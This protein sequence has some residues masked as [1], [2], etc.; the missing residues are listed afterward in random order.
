MSNRTGAHRGTEVRSKGGKWKINTTRPLLTKLVLTKERETRGWQQY[1][2]GTTE[3]RSEQRCSIES[4][5]TATR[6]PKHNIR[7]QWTGPTGIFGLEPSNKGTDT[8]GK[9]Q[10][11]A[12]KGRVKRVREEKL[13]AAGEAE[14]TAGGGEN[15]LH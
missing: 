13:A 6:A 5:L 12:H 3:G 4:W 7:Q 1:P 8:R 14:G 9:M 10:S 11:R 2:R 15:D